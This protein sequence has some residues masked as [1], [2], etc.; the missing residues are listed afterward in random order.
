MSIEKLGK[1]TAPIITHAF[2]DL[3]RTNAYKRGMPNERFTFVP[4]P[5]WSKTASEMRRDLEGKDPIT[6]KLVIQEII[7]ALTRPLSE[8]DKKTG[9]MQPSMGPKV[10]GPDTPDDLQQFFHDEGMTDYL[11]II[12]PTREKVDAMLKETSHKPDEVVGKM[13]GGAFEPWSY[14]V[15]QVAVNAVMAGAKPEYFPVILSIAA[16]GVPALFSSTNSFARAVVI[17][18]PIRNQIQMNYGIG[19]MGPFSQANA[20]IGRAWTLMSK[21]LG[22]AGIPG[23]TYLGSQGNSVNWVNIVIAEN[24]EASPWV[25]LHVQ[26]GFKKAESV[27]SIFAG[28][29]IHAGQGAKGGGVIEK[30][31]FDHQISAIFESITGFFGGFVVCDPLVA[32]A[33]KEQGYDNKEKLSE[34]L[35][36]NTTMTVKEYKE[37]NFVS[38]FDFPRAD[39]GIEPYASWLKLPDEAII[40]R[41]A[42]PTDINIVVAGGETQ[43]FFQYG[44]MRYA[45]SISIDKWR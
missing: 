5:I 30:P 36:K 11:P 38:S 15:E 28:L 26:K 43:A 23:E 32:R 42:R 14:T 6:G 21:N 35:N 29:G 8:D 9:L 27:V 44:G 40:P 10:Y 12:L 17:N 31:Q 3:A 7:E 33:L 41:F 37:T 4:H 39:R 16:S 45:V 22:N 19:A 25:P 1:P 20:T 34:W 18:G 2:H 13:A 24:E